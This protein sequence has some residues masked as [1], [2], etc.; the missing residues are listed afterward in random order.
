MIRWVF[1]HQNKKSVTWFNV[2]NVIIIIMINA[3]EKLK[4]LTV[5]ANVLKNRS[6]FPIFF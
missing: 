4:C 6:D 2:K 1:I 5:T 3:W